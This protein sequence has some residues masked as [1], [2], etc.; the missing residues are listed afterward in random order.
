MSKR[1]GGGGAQVLHIKDR[2]QRET[3]R[4]KGVG[5]WVGGGPGVTVAA[6]H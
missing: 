5:G 1:S 3:L 2:M 4:Q 6:P